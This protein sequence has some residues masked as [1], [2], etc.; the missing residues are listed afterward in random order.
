MLSKA[1]EVHVTVTDNATGDTLTDEDEARWDE[2]DSCWGFITAD[3]EKDVPA[4]GD[5]RGWLDT[6][7]E[8]QSLV[9]EL[10]YV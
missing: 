8:F 6:D 1:R 5:I 7:A 9:D 10:H 3:P 4:W 2:V